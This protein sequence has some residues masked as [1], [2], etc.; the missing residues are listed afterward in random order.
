MGHVWSAR[1]DPCAC[2]ANR[3]YSGCGGQQDHRYEVDTIVDEGR[4]FPVFPKLTP[5]HNTEKIRFSRS[6]TAAK[7]AKSE[8][9][10]F[11]CLA[12]RGRM[13]FALRCGWQ[14]GYC[15]Q[16]ETSAV[17]NKLGEERDSTDYLDYILLEVSP[18]QSPSN[19]RF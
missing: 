5:A 1:N 18:R 8:K 13:L 2:Y 4:L 7:S 3:I 12:Y 14:N 9:Y 11:S 15:V 10:H 16:F 6:L 19:R 17:A